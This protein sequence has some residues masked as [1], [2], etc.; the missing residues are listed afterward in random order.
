MLRRAQSYRTVC[1]LVEVG[2][3]PFLRTFPIG[4]QQF[5]HYHGNSMRSNIHGPFE[6]GHS[7]VTNDLTKVAPIEP[8]NAHNR[9]I[10]KQSLL[11]FHCVPTN[12]TRRF[13][14]VTN[15]HSNRVGSVVDMG[16]VLNRRL[17]AC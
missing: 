16:Y 9:R 6:I 1:F 10:L 7:V 14:T 17:A 13:D 8:V 3:A 5:F 4:R 12:S 11:S 15:A 2:D